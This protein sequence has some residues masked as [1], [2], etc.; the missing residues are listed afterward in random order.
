M[1]MRFRLRQPAV[2]KMEGGG[3]LNRMMLLPIPELAVE[4]GDIITVWLAAKTNSG[5]E[6]SQQIY[7]GIR[8]G[9]S[10]TE[11]VTNQLYIAP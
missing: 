9:D 2:D 3:Y 6:I 8:Q 5:I 4:D 10:Y 1:D 7:E 11:N